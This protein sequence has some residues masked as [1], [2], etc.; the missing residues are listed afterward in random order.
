MAANR[1]LVRASF[2]G[3]L[4]A[5]SKLDRLGASVASELPRFSL[6]AAAVAPASFREVV[7]TQFHAQKDRPAGADTNA[8]LDSALK[9]LVLV[10]S[11]CGV[12]RCIYLSSLTLHR[13]V[14]AG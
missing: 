14:L 8:L 12:F 10:S 7:L 13:G 3:L 2:K 1:A 4:R 11:S 9:A 5:A 6:P